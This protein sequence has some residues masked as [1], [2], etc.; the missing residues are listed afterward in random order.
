LSVK[1]IKEMPTQS[2]IQYSVSR[3]LQNPDIQDQWLYPSVHAL[4]AGMCP[5][6]MSYM[7]SLLPGKLSTLPCAFITKP[8]K[9][10]VYACWCCEDTDSTRTS[11]DEWCNEI[12]ILHRLMEERITQVGVWLAE[13]GVT[14][15]YVNVFLEEL[16][17]F[18]LRPSAFIYRR[19][20][21]DSFQRFRGCCLNTFNL[22]ATMALFV[23]GKEQP[24]AVLCAIDTAVRKCD[25]RKQQLDHLSQVLLVFG[26]CL[27][28][29]AREHLLSSSFKLQPAW[30]TVHDCTSFLGR[31]VSAHH[32]VR[33]CT[34]DGLDE[35]CCES[36]RILRSVSAFVWHRCTCLLGS[37]KRTCVTTI[38]QDE[39]RNVL[40][41]LSSSRCRPL[42]TPWANWCIENHRF[43][44]TP[45]M[46]S[47]VRGYLLLLAR[48]K[49][50][51]DL[52]RHAVSFLFLGPGRAQICFLD[53]I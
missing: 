24:S 38:D 21:C 26:M 44:A 33:A 6:M 18:F 50:S 22:P 29:E 13:A 49:I 1:I 7:C 20:F 17:V 30:S 37:L 48:K 36:Q 11:I 40:L 15:E 53:N 12:A 43:T 31:H 35:D 39:I 25:A 28:D 52:A 10:I 46:Q 8:M 2:I 19:D 14:D 5:A 42:L 34:D 47:L 4:E 45:E 32:I 23:L 27:R 9:K 3:L 51:G 41:N 16:D